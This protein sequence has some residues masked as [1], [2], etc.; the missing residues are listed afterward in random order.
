MASTALT[1][2]RPHAAFA[3]CTQLLSA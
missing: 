1:Q 3:T 2:K